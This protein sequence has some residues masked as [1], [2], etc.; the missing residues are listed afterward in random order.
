MQCTP[1]KEQHSL[2]IK[3]ESKM[4]RTPLFNGSEN[5]GNTKKGVALAYT[6]KG[7][8]GFFAALEQAKI[9]AAAQQLAKQQ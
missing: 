4:T 5:A 3:K 6:G 8:D 1:R 9:K 7:F 2:I